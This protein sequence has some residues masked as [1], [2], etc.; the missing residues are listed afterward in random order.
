VFK[1]LNQ[2]GAENMDKAALFPVR[3]AMFIAGDDESRTPAVLRL[4]AKLGF[5][6]SIPAH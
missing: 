2:I 4:V 1:T 3:P 5:E 6:A